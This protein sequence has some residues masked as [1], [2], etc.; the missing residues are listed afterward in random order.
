[1]SSLDIDV[2]AYSGPCV[3]RRTSIKL[4]S[5]AGLT[6]ILAGC[7]GDDDDTEPTEDDDTTDEDR[8]GGRLQAAQEHDE[9]GVFEPAFR[10]SFN[11]AQ[12]ATNISDPLVR[13][14]SELEIEAALAE[15][16]EVEDE[17]RRF[18]FQLRDDVVFHNGEP[19]TADDVLFT[20]QRNIENETGPAADRLAELTPIDDGGVEVI[21]EHTIEFNWQEPMAAGLALLTDSG[22]P[23]A[24]PISQ[25][26]FEEMGEEDFQLKPVCTGPFQIEEHDIDTRLLLTRND[27]Y[28]REDEDGNQLPYLDEIEIQFIPE[29]SSGVNALQTDEI[30][31]HLGLSTDVMDQIE[32][33]DGLE[34]EAVPHLEFRFL[35]V[36]HDREPF[37]NRDFRMGVAKG[38]NREE[39]IEEV[40]H[41]YAV[42]GHG[43]YPPGMEW[44]YRED[45]PDNQEYD[46]EEAQQ[47]IEESGMDPEFRIVGSG[48]MEVF[49]Q[50]LSQQMDRIG[51]EVD[52]DINPSATFIDQLDT[53]DFDAH[54]LGSLGDVDPTTSLNKIYH[55]DGS[56]N[57]WI[58]NYEDDEL[59]DLLEQA[60]R[61]L[62]QEQ[63]IEHLQEIETILNE[64]AVTPFIAHQQDVAV[65]ASNVQNVN[66]FA[67]QQRFES[68][69]KG[70]GI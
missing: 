18:V 19:L 24:N 67:G 57:H 29:P 35:A 50:V 66:L 32:G 20:V 11:H 15:D 26:A 70:E 2:D 42:K 45:G 65:Y 1:M 44:I 38:I 51:V 3:D 40:W 14:N 49:G 22:N 55:P 6:S 63:R 5:A 21:D 23:A 58:G 41:G 30:E 34:I 17:G 13:V 48:G 16:W 27:E 46:P 53:G 43:P 28:F 10:P 61:E 62:D 47:L 64:D 68:V 7:M 59:I 12:I 33:A 8:Y 52:V 4:L 37:S 60:D 69:W 25:T 54:S 31:Y 9:T 56:W 36:N 39:M